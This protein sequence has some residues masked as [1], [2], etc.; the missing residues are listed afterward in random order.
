[1]AIDEIDLGIELV[2]FALDHRIRVSC[3]TL[4]S[5]IHLI[6][7]ALNQCNELGD[8]AGVYIGHNKDIWAIFDLFSI[9]KTVDSYEYQLRFMGYHASISKYSNQDIP[10]ASLQL[11]QEADR[12]GITL[13]V[14]CFSWLVIALTNH[15]KYAKYAHGLMDGI[16]LKGLAPNVEIWTCLFNY[17]ASTANASLTLELDQQR[18]FGNPHMNIKPSFQMLYAMICSFIWNNKTITSYLATALSVYRELTEINSTNEAHLYQRDIYFGILTL[19][20]KTGSIEIALNQIKK[21]ILYTSPGDLS[22]SSRDSLAHSE[23]LIYVELLLVT[24]SRCDCGILKEQ[25]LVEIIELWATVST[26]SLRD[27]AAITQP[28]TS[29]DS[30][31]QSST[32]M[33]S[34]TQSSTS[35]ESTTQSST[36]M[37]STTQ[38]GTSME[39]TTQPGTS[40]ES[41]TQSS[42]SM[43]ST[44]QSD[45]MSLRDIVNNL[46]DGPLPTV[47]AVHAILCILSQI[48]A[49]GDL[50]ALLHGTAFQFIIN[51]DIL[52]VYKNTPVDSSLDS[53]HSDLLAQEQINFL[54]E[55]STVLPH[56]PQ[57][58]MVH[59]TPDTLPVRTTSISIH[60]K[61]IWLNN[62]GQFSRYL[63]KER[64]PNM[65]EQNFPF[66]AISHKSRDP[67]EL[68]DMPWGLSKQ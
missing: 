57:L 37:E 15:P 5:L 38:P 65:L 1:M 67:R 7:T 3:S 27:I 23:L 64:D 18:R 24:L 59:F 36:S 39:S 16:L 66:R 10:L 41:T 19:C 45:T 60:S 46:S 52:E 68:L 56:L 42:T 43:E 40:M 44:T 62:F 29:I 2:K 49:P 34:T 61:D 54:S 14:R 4:N 12:L 20:A 22:Q 8:Q 53:V 25:F 6:G 58:K 30:T 21:Y 13:S 51:E 33:E 31:T 28:G 55:L 11:F 47:E 63:K 17:A 50:D 32:S 26:G 48:G 35:M 9:S